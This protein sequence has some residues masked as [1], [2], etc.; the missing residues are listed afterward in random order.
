MKDH[1]IRLTDEARQQLQQLLQS[2][3]RPVRVVRRALILLK[4]D[5]GYTDEEIVEHIGCS[6]RMTRRVRKRFCTAGLEQALYDAPRSGAPAS[7]TLRQQQ[8]V[9]AL[10]CSAPPEGRV[11]W[12]LELLCQHAAEQGIV[13]SV[14]KSEVALWLKAHDLKPWRKKLGVFPSSPRNSASAWRMSLTSMKSRSILSNR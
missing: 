1:I 13:P 10:A 6:E 14:S 12:T 2:G 11:R 4:S 8:Q 3:T 7:F 5:E 9:I